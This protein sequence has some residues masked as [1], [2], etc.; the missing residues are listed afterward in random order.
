LNPRSIHFRLVL[1]YCVITIVTCAI[2]GVIISMTVREKIY[3]EVETLFTFRAKNIA[4]NILPHVRDKTHAELAEQIGQVFYPEAANRFIRILGPE[5]EVVYASGPAKNGHFDPAKID[6]PKGDI[7]KKRTVMLAP[8]DPLYIVAVQAP[9][10][11]N[12]YTVETGAETDVMED[13]LSTLISTQVYLLPSLVLILTGGGLMLVRRSLAPVED[14]RRSAG[15]IT[16]GNLR[17]RLP[18]ARTGDAIEQLSVTLNQMLGRLSDAYDQSNRFAADAAHELRTPLAIM[19]GEL[20][21]VAVDGKLDDRLKD[22]IG[23]MLEETDRLSRITDMLL[24]MSRLDAGESRMQDERL[25]FAALARDTA[26]GMSLLADEKEIRL[27]INAPSPVRVR[28]DAARL[29][30]VVVNLLDNA[31]KYTPEGGRVALKVFAT[32]N[33]AVLEV[34]DTGIG[35]PAESLPHVFERFYR[36]DK[37]RSRD[38]GGTGLGLSIAQSICHAHHGT[39]GIDSAEGKGTRCRVELSLAAA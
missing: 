28:G 26:E 11:G 19:R 39:I 1:W 2:V 29:K 23:S 12:I 9:I 7:P 38:Q 18:V 32:G 3:S 31:I 25:D 5:R 33:S 8:G 15:E 13:T 24:A 34:E 36:V 37:A 20:E 35:I 30:E 22:R 6:V 4:E 21:S 27:D 14:I 17:N 10:D 16:F